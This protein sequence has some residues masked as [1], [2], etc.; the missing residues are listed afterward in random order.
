MRPDRTK[1]L[2]GA[3]MDQYIIMLVPVIMGVVLTVYT[4]HITRKR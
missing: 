4:R 1:P 3:R 2:H